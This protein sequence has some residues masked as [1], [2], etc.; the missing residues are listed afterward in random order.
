MFK[1]TLEEA[2]HSQRSRSQ[3]ATL[4]RPVPTKGK[5]IG[6][7][8]ASDQSKDLVNQFQDI[9]IERQTIYERSEAQP[10]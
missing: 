6:F 3:I 10:H 7:R 4:K 1:L 5:A 8:P 9:L 2:E